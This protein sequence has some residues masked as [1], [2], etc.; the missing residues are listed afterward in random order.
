MF[1]TT[2]VKQ[3]QIW[4]ITDGR[5]NDDFDPT[6]PSMLKLFSVKAVKDVFLLV[7]IFRN[8]FSFILLN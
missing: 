8:I 6:T 7:H 5:E 1:E 2:E 4:K 3:K